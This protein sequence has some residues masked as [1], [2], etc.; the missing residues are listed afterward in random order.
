MH[1]DSCRV[2]FSN[3]LLI[4]HHFVSTIRA[5]F[6]LFVLI[7]MIRRQSFNI[8]EFLHTE[9]AIELILP[10]EKNNNELHKNYDEAESL[11]QS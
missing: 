2:F 11:L 3:I 6:I 5:S 9:N 4:Y 10:N 7:A 8:I 1:S